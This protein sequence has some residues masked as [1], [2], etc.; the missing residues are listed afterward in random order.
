[1]VVGIAARRPCNYH[2]CIGAPDTKH[3][4]PAL[5]PCVGLPD[6][7]R[8]FHKQ[9]SVLGLP[10][11]ETTTHT[12]KEIVLCASAIRSGASNGEAISHSLQS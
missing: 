7:R 6:T 8:L 12:R 10:I 2:F 4:S 11:H 5:L 1:M 9:L 3:E